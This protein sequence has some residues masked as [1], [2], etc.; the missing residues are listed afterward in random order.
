MDRS[1]AV[2]AAVAADQRALSE[3]AAGHV[4]EARDAVSRAI[5]QL[6]TALGPTAPDVA[7]VLLHG[8]QI[9]RAAG[10]PGAAR[11]L[12]ADAVTAARTWNS[13]DEDLVSLRFEG[14]AEL[15]MLDQAL[16]DLDAAEH[17]LVAAL[18][19]AREIASAQRSVLLLTNALGV[20]YKFAGRLEDAQRCYDEVY[21]LLRASPATTPDDLAGLFHNLAGLAHSRGD[22]ASGIL[23]AQRGITIRRQIGNEDSLD[24]ARDHG[25]LGALQH[26]AGR[27][28]EARDSY[29]LAEAATTAAL[30]PDH[31]EVAILLAN[32]AALESDAGDPAGAVELY[33]RALT[34]LAAALG[35]DHHEVAFVHNSLQQV[36][37]NSERQR[38]KEQ[39]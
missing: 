10:D 11:V 19:D 30:G 39:T 25:G 6:I 7:N 29:A 18:D 13:E 4:A 3:L 9:E 12:A 24:L 20:T 21:D 38:D 1:E 5:A 22:A 36:L 27:L 33:R 26:L 2:A 37:G 31:H 28:D 14:E 17:R 32:R 8:A 23:W 34:L 16:G 35:G 15:A